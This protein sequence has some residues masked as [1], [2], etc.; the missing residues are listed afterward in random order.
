MRKIFKIIVLV[1]IAT[2]VFSQD[3]LTL[4]QAVELALKNNYDIA[5]LKNKAA[6]ASIN[7]DATIANFLPKAGLSFAQSASLN[8]LRQRVQTSSIETKK[9]GVTGS[10]INPALNVT[11]TLFD[12]M[13]M[14]ATQNKLKRVMEVGELN[15]QDTMQTMVASAITAYFDVVSAKQQLKALNDAIKISEERVQLAEKQF[16]VGYSSKVDWLQ[17]RVDLNEQ[18]SLIINQTKLIEQK[19]AELNRILARAPETNF[20]TT[21]SIPF[22]DDLSKI[23]AT[24]LDNRNLQMKVAAKNIEVQRFAR[25]EIFANYLP[26][27]AIGGSYGYSQTKNSAGFTLLNQVQGFSE[28]VSLNV[29]LFNGTLT[30]KQVKVAD[31]NVLNAET[32]YNKI[33]L[34]TKVKYFKAQKDYEKAIESLNL[35]EENILLVKENLAIALERYR[36]KQSTAIELRQAEQS[37]TDAFTRLVIARFAAKTAETELLRLMGALVK[38]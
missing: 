15:Y 14:F 9:N 30:R 38:N 11:W 24:E 2:P 33:H 23:A 3:V 35:E 27:L 29:P 7:S 16:Q 6:I 1:L 17:A 19:K 8:D 21:D 4:N 36:L 22:N 5:I 32:T 12:G 25:K 10:N 34:L 18:K 31:I 28:A 20:E 26:Q 13:K 37:Y